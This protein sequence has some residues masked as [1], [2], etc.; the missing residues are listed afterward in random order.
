MIISPKGDRSREDSSPEKMENECHDTLN[1]DGREQSQEILEESKTPSRIQDFANQ[2]ER[3]EPRADVPKM[4]PLS[5]RRMWLFF[6]TLSVGG[7]H[8]EYI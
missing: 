6:F 1:R 2:S 3:T 5:S 4:A 8:I 7:I